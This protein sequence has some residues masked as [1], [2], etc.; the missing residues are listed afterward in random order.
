MDAVKLVAVRG[1]SRGRL[2]PATRDDART[3]EAG[4]ERII[5][6][7]PRGDRSHSRFS[8]ARDLGNGRVRHVGH[9]RP[10]FR[11]F[12]ESANQRRGRVTGARENRHRRR[13]RRVFL[14]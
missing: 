1:N 7:P 13:F 9:D 14:I 6:G 11:E 3:I 2:A 12:F 5:E 4:T 8:L 10:M